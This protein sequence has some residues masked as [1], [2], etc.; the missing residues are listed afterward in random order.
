MRYALKQLCK[1]KKDTRRKGETRTIKSTRTLRALRENIITR[2]TAPFAV[3]IPW[4]WVSD[5]WPFFLASKHLLD[6]LHEPSLP[7]RRDLMPRAGN[8]F[9]FLDT[10]DNAVTLLRFLC[11]ILLLANFQ[12]SGMSVFRKFLFFYF[13]LFIS[14]FGN[15]FYWTND[16]IR[17]HCCKFI[18]KFCFWPISELPKSVF[19]ENCVFWIFIYALALLLFFLNFCLWKI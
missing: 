17:S 15:Y 1:R 8:L 10:R 19:F 6:P 16:T 13:Y 12:T 5:V 3:Q 9:N 7:Q 11:T 2:K 14:R 4:P 18:S